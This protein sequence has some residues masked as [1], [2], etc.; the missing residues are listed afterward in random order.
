MSKM[1]AH[2]AAAEARGR[3]TKGRVAVKAVVKAA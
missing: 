3:A 1:T 2:G